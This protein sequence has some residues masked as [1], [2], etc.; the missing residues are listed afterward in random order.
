[1]H[2]SESEAYLLRQLRDAPQ[3]H[4]FRYTDEAHAS[5]LKDLFGALAGGE[6]EN[7]RLLFP[8]GLP[9]D[10]KPESWKLSAAQGAL[11]GAEYSPAARGKPCGHI[12]KS[13][14]ATYRCK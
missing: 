4:G 9:T 11:D 12:F 6:E 14:E 1:M 7:L 5:L 10:N 8:G 2:L 13:G 3:Q